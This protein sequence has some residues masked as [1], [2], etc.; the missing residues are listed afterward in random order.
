[1]VL[2]GVNPA[3]MSLYSATSASLKPGNATITPSAIREIIM[4]ALSPADDLGGAYDPPP[5][6]SFVML[7]KTFFRALLR[8]GNTAITAIGLL[9]LALANR[10]IA[11]VFYGYP[12]VPEH[13]RIESGSLNIWPAHGV[14]HTRLA[15]LYW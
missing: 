11:P 6:T 8:S 7:V 10:A 4:T 13:T 1:M 15:P 3:V 2:Y 5:P 12:P 14:G 9:A